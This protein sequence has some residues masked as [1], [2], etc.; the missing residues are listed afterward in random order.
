PDPLSPKGWG[1]GRA[2]QIPSRGACH[3]PVNERKRLPVAA[4]PQKSTFGAFGQAFGGPREIGWHRCPV[5][6]RS[7]GRWRSLRGPYEG[8]KHHVSYP[9]SGPCL[10][11]PVLSHVRT[12]FLQRPG[13]AWLPLGGRATGGLVPA[14]PALAHPARHR[15]ALR[16]RTSGY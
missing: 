10:S 3:L 15:T 6:G 14:Q 8:G 4:I 13:Q 9:I 16:Y 11:L 7:G 5:G 1:N 2:G 12:A